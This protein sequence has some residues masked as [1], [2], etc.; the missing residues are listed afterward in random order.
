MQR[1]R[2]MTAKQRVSANLSNTLANTIRALGLK[3]IGWTDFDDPTLND[4]AQGYGYVLIYLT[5]TK[6]FTALRAKP[7]DGYA[8]S[9]RYV[10]VARERFTKDFFHM[11]RCHKQVA[12]LCCMPSPKKKLL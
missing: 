8:Y 6:R 1:K 3:V 5:I 2:S 11:E 12:Q 4:Y 9:D 7:H 10:I